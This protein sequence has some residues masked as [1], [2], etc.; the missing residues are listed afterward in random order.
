[1]LG[2]TCLMLLG[3]ECE[4]GAGISAVMFAFVE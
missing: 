1:M 3:S 4:G 2:G